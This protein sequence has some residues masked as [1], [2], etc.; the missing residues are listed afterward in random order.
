MPGLDLRVWLG[1][2]S[3]MVGLRRGIA[4]FTW[5][6]VGCG[7][8]ATEM[9]GTEGSTGAVAATSGEA[10][11]SGSS[12][13]STGDPG[14]S[15]SSGSPATSSSTGE[16]CV[17]VP[18]LENPEVWNCSTTSQDCPDCYKCTHNWS[19]D[20]SVWAVTEGTVCVPVDENPVADAEPC[21]YGDSLGFDDCGANS[22]CWTSG[23]DAAGGYCVPFCADQKTCEEG[24]VCI[25]SGDG[26]LGCLPGCDPFEPSCPDPSEA[27]LT[28]INGPVCQ[29]G[30]DLPTS[31]GEECTWACGSG[32]SCVP[33]DSYGPGCE[34]DSCCT[35]LCDADHLCSVG[36]QTCL[37]TCGEPPEELS[38]CGVEPPPNPLQCP[39][40]DA[41]PNYPWCSSEVDTCGRAF[42]G[43]ND[44]LDLCFCAE[45][46]EDASSCPTPET[47]N[48]E[49]ICGD[50]GFGS[51]TCLLSCADG[52]TCP[53]GMVCDE[54][55]YPGLCM[56]GAELEP[57]CST[58]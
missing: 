27:C 8:A 26:P 24:T 5:C 34:S 41:E 14:G 56:W 13:S 51:D 32:L 33:A 40:E 52:Q 19:G 21:T 20:T 50:Q 42:G 54:E 45:A 43:G 49:V 9:S 25:G 35:S 12:S 17:D 46:C 55:S 37:G 7:A 48:P 6:L 38:V 44:C 28:G 23:P 57:G 39:P 22:F 16:S 36:E 1:Y 18:P 3:F 2:V 10:E 30:T 31:E 53:N 29:S 15:G 58:D 4:V 11:T 47:G